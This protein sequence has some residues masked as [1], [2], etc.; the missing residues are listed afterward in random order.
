MK[1]RMAI[2]VAAAMCMCLMTGCDYS[3]IIDEAASELAEIPELQEEE[4]NE[5]VNEDKDTEEETAGEDAGQEEV[6]QEDAGQEETEKEDAGAEGAASELCFSGKDVNGEPVN[7]AEVFAKNRITV[8]NM[9][10]SWCPPCA[11]EIP[12]LEVINN[13]L[14]EKDCEVVGILLDGEDPEGLRDAKEILEDAG[15]S[16]LNV[17]GSD[18]MWDTL[19]MDA[20]PTTFFVDSAGK[21]LGDPIVG[22]DPD[23][24]R[25]TVDELLSKM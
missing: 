15:V 23:G 3:T 19:G 11:A 4:V 2:I 1:K 7:T 10:A 12:E 8:V 18:S 21:I 6:E 17:I 24:Y 9:W 22:A 13:E 25:Q 20:I 16:Y 5:E 14:K